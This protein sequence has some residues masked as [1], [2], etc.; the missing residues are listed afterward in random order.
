MSVSDMIR[1]KFSDWYYGEENKDAG[2]VDMAKKKRQ[3]GTAVLELESRIIARTVETRDGVKLSTSVI[4]GGPKVM[5]LCAPLGLHDLSIYYPMMLHFGS[6]YTYV[7]WN[8]RG[9]F[10]SGTPKRNRQISIRD[11]AQDALQVL[12][13]RGFDHADVLVGHSMGVSVGLEFVLLY[14]EKVNSLIFLNGAHGNVFS[15]AFQPAVRIPF[16][17]NISEWLVRTLLQNNPRLIVTGIRNFMK[18]APVQVGLNLWSRMFG[19]ETARNASGDYYLSNF[20]ENYFNG[21]CRDDKTSKNYL[22]SFQELNAHSVYHLLH[23]IQHPTLLIS[24]VF[25]YVTP[26]YHMREMAREMKNSTHISDPWSTHASLLENPELVVAQ[27]Q[28][29]LAKQS[30]RFQ[31]CS[32]THFES[33]QTVSDSVCEE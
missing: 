30:S 2:K 16:V 6:E 33:I 22:R 5:L 31:R 1:S 7:G 13:Q 10:K 29:F 32:S 8:Y 14:P 25:D 18:F 17:G 12:E 21:I 20:F 9:M 27:A 19:S 28:V 24:G 15:T 23:T 4:K 26:S 3:R 11:H